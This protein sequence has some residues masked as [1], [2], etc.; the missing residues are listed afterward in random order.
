[1]AK[2]NNQRKVRHIPV[3]DAEATIGGS[4]SMA[5]RRPNP[6]PEQGVR[7]SRPEPI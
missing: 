5:R 7:I 2:T 3:Q 1:M 6:Q 4:L